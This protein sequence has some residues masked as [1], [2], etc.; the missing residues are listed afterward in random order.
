MSYSVGVVVI[1]LEI[2]HL[3]CSSSLFMCSSYTPKDNIECHRGWIEV[4][5]ESPRSIEDNNECVLDS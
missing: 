1:I 2:I 5:T 3:N 4:D